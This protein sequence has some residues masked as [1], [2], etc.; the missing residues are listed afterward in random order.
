MTPASSEAT[1]HAEETSQ[2]SALAGRHFEAKSPSK[3][4]LLLPQVWW[5]SGLFPVVTGVRG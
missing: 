5:V 2:V 3:L 1:N 4:R